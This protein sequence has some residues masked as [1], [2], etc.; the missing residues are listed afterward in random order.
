MPG[1]ARAARSQ[2]FLAS[3]R[4]AADLVAT[5]DVG[6]DDRVVELGAGTGILTTALAARAGLVLA[7]ELDARL[8]GRLQRQFARRANTVILHADALDVPL[9]ATPYAV[10]RAIRAAADGLPSSESRSAT[11][12]R[13]A[14]RPCTPWSSSSS[15]SSTSPA[16]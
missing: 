7:V 12:T 2:H 11:A 6:G 4:L 3:S 13:S 15:S 5:A 8:V 16:T 14:R 1:Y 9:P 10:W